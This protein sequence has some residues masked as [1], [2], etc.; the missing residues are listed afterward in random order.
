MHIRPA[1]AKDLLILP[2]LSM[3]LEELERDWDPLIRDPRRQKSEY[4]K[5]FTKRFRQRNTQ[6]FVAEDNGIIGFVMGEIQ[7]VPDIY[8]QPFKGYVHDLYVVKKYREKGV[9]RALMNEMLKWFKQKKIK[10]VEITAYLDN[11]NAIDFYKKCGFEPLT[12]N[13]RKS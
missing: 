8:T 12:L 11:E 10:R 1:K 3:R 2:E 9:G 7:K 4:I 13:L 6:I 5:Y